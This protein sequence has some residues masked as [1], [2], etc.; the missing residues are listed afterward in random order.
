MACPRSLVSGTQSTP[1]HLLHQAETEKP[2]D[3]ASVLPLHLHS[4]QQHRR[5]TFA[6]IK[7]QFVK[8]FCHFSAKAT[9]KCLV[10]TLM[11][12]RRYTQL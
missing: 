12:A 4:G 11:F 7:G 1:H 5:K 10:S 2:I 3:A 6:V 9:H 8:Q